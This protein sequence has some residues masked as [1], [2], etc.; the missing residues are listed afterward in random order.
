VLRKLFFVAAVLGGL[1]LSPAVESRA[2]SLAAPS[3]SDAPSC[4]ITLKGK[5]IAFDAHAPQIPEIEPWTAP[6][7]EVGSAWYGLDFSDNKTLVDRAKLLDG[8]TVQVTGH[9][10]Q[11]RLGGLIPRTIDVLVV[12]RLEAMKEPG[13]VKK[14][15]QVE[16]KGQ[17]LFRADHLDILV[18][19]SRLI[20]N[21][22]TYV[23]D[24]GSNSD[25]WHAVVG[26]DG[27]TAIVTGTLKGDTITATA[28]KADTDFVHK[29][30]KVEVKGQL[31]WNRWVRC[32]VTRFSVST[33]N[34]YFGLEFASK[35]L[36]NLAGKLADQTVVLSGTLEENTD[37]GDIITVT[38]LKAAELPKV[39]E[40]V[41]VAVQGKLQFVIKHFLTGE[42]LFTCDEM[43]AAFSRSWSLGYGVTVDG[44]LYQFDLGNDAKLR[45]QVEKLIGHSVLAEGTLKKDVVQVTSVKALS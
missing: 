23:L 45:E 18:P 20:V 44:R 31:I 14:T 30:I 15:V 29:T 33:A 11:R 41:S 27:H 38:A 3:K 16:M 17:F 36:E 13:S 1:S 22:K 24:F 12:S 4:I 5:L 35:D 21:G 26:L 32:R 2:D 7:L 6:S 28:I 19:D 10:E 8:K 42:V 40:K 43:P 34:E 39:P 25:L 9:L 37:R